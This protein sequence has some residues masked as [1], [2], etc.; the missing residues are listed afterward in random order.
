MLKISKVLFIF[1]FAFGCINLHAQTTPD[2]QLAVQYFQ[3]KEFDKAVIYYEKLFDRKPIPLYYNYYISCLKETKDFKKAEKVIKKL[4][5]QKPENLS[6][7]VDLGLIYKATDDQG[8]AK[9]QFQ[10]SIKQLS[11]NQE[12][13]LN[14]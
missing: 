11:S 12:Q 4:I 7:L 9:E 13:I 14:L 10:K 1:L 8:K 2:E 3:N 6:Y 5:K